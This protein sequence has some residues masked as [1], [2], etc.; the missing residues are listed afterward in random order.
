MVKVLKV[1]F[2]L[3]VISSSTKIL[4][5]EAMCLLL[6]ISR[7]TTMPKLKAMSMR[8]TQESIRHPQNI[9]SCLFEF[10]IISLTWEIMRQ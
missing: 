5:S 6:V 3:M 1:M 4:K 7:L 8:T 2:V 10:S 9:R